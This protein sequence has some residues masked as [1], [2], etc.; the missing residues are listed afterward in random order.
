MPETG[1]QLADRLARLA[2]ANESAVNP[3]A[4]RIAKSFQARCCFVYL[5]DL[6]SILAQCDGQTVF[7]A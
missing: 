1:L 3:E 7:P 2:G 4:G 5:H 6:N